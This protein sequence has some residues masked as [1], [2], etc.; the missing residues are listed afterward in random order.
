MSRVSDIQNTTNKYDKKT[1]KNLQ[2]VQVIVLVHPEVCGDNVQFLLGSIQTNKDQEGT[3]T[4]AHHTQ[5]R[6]HLCRT[7][8]KGVQQKAVESRG[9]K[10]GG[11]NYLE[12]PEHVAE[13]TSGRC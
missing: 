5:Q 10:T 11:M 12:F 4:M 2:H 3:H 13:E 8:T 9:G 7:E 6:P 1:S